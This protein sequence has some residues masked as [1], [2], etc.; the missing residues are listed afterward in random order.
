MLWYLLLLFIILFLLLS[1]FTKYEFI[2]NGPTFSVKAKIQNSI[3]KSNIQI[4]KLNKN[5]KKS[6]DT[7]KQLSL[8]INNLK[9]TYTTNLN[10]EKSKN[11]DCNLKVQGL[12]AQIT[13]LNAQVSQ[14]IKKI[15]T[16]KNKK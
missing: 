14:L 5:L 15:K 12:N 11:S 1:I 7:N 3:D 13:G 16:N 6:Q 8:K 9:D 4:N 2:S 10:A